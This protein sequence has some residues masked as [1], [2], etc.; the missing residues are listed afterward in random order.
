MLS[1]M[2]YAVSKIKQAIPKDIL[3][4]SFIDYVPRFRTV[5]SAV[6]VDTL[7]KHK[8]IRDIVLTDCNLIGANKIDIAIQPR[9]CQILDSNHCVVRVPKTHTQNRSIIEVLDATYLP[10]SGYLM[11]YGTIQAVSDSTI[12]T[13]KLLNSLRTPTIAGTVNTEIVS[14]N[15]IAII[16]A[17]TIPTNMF[18]TVMVEHDD[19]LSQMKLQ[20]Y[21]K[22]GELCIH[23]CKSYIWANKIID[24]DKAEIDGGYSLNRYTSIIEGYESAFEDYTTY[25]NDVWKKTS[26]MADPA[27]YSNFLNAITKIGLQ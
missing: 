4:K 18:I 1:A 14:E 10:Q 15:T 9:W 3:E 25:F 24:M 13:N 12:G 26:F 21:H 8:V 17:G 6:N 22:F 16:G 20:A 19:N 7:I 5:K 27:R 2:D 23:A 11:P